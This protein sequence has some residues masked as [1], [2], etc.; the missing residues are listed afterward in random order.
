MVYDSFLQDRCR[1]KW[2]CP[3]ATGKVDFC[4]CKEQCSP[5]SYGRTVYTKPEW[6]LRLFTAVPRG[7]VLWKQEMKNRTT[8]ER[9]NKR[10]LVDY[11]LEKARVRGK[12][13]WSWRL[14]VHSAN[15]HLDAWLKAS[16]FNFIDLLDKLN[17]KAA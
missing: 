8:S 13:R 4:S 1:I 11:G 15:L 6:D 5:S 2:R 9:V 12:K 3:L 16:R 10:I 17:S 7:S 14:L